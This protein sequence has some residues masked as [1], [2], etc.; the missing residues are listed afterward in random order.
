MWAIPLSLVVAAVVALG[1]FLL[2][3]VGLA[4]YV[5]QLHPLSPELI[6]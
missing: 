5:T 3:E 2:E 1:R 6:Q 4:H